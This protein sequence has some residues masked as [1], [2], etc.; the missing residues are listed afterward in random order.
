MEHEPT[1]RE[2]GRDD[3]RELVVC[4][5]CSRTVEVT[6]DPIACAACGARFAREEALTVTEHNT[7]RALVHAMEPLPAERGMTA[8][9]RWAMTGG[10]MTVALAITLVFGTAGAMV[11]WL[12]VGALMVAAKMRSGPGGMFR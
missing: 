4:I 5:K 9:Q 6:P 3:D 10:F 8:R 11:A 1:Y 7:T 2:Q 12:A